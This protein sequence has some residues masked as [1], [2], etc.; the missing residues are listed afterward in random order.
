MGVSGQ[1]RVGIR[2]VQPVPV[3]SRLKGQDVTEAEETSASMCCLAGSTLQT[4][5][6]CDLGRAQAEDLLFRLLTSA[7]FTDFT[8]DPRALCRTS[9]QHEEHRSLDSGN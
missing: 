5:A 4:T 3:R 2:R 6:S 8:I 9:L 7:S 1:V